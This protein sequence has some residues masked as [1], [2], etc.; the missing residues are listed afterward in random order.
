MGVGEPFNVLLMH[1]QR[2]GSCDLSSRIRDLGSFA[3]LVPKFSRLHHRTCMISL[4]PILLDFMSGMSSKYLC[5]SCG[6]AFANR[7]ALE[8]GASSPASLAL[9]A[10]AFARI[11]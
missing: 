3:C 9:N 10:L 5:R 4:F 6:G 1:L 2:L 8:P 11:I 7:G